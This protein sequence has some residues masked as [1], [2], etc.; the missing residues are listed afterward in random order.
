LLRGSQRYSR[1]GSGNSNIPVSIKYPAGNCS[2]PAR[3]TGCIYQKLSK[4]NEIVA[5]WNPV[6]NAGN[7][8]LPPEK[9]SG[10]NEARIIDEM[11][12]INKARVQN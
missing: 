9:Y 7:R 5:K 1:S 11:C 4:V 12:G 3:E 10:S 8:I 2:D 6:N